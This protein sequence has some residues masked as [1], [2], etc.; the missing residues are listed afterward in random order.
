MP[1]HDDATRLP[2]DFDG[3]VRLFPL[4]GLVLLPHAMQGLHLFEPRYC[5]ML[6]RALAT[7]G[8][9]TM[10]TLCGGLEDAALPSPTLHPQVCIGKVVT[11]TAL[12]DG[13]HN[14]VL[15]GA[16][17]A[18]ITRELDTPAPFREAE[19]A[20][21]N[22]GYGDPAEGST[23]ELR[24]ELLDQ[25]ALLLPKVMIV[26]EGLRNLLSIELELGM[27]TDLIA[28]TVDFS[29]EQKLTLLAEPMVRRRTKLLIQWLRER[30]DHLG[31]D[32]ASPGEIEDFP[33]RFSEN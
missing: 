21:L 3:R 6:E 26:Q 33:P 29:M 19:V 1:D 10:A 11:H 30:I 22:D 23:S 14:V 16:R 18:L 15:V 25:F 4:P 7:D 17:R 28:H 9:I 32:A 20:V 24:G 13:T 27:L 2:D 8:L 5:A 31:R 12:P